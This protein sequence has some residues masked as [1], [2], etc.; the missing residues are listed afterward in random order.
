[1]YISMKINL[2][3]NALAMKRTI[4]VK[5]IDKGRGTRGSL[6]HDVSLPF[7]NEMINQRRA[8]EGFRDSATL[9]LCTRMDIRYS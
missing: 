9:K 8:S 1:M 7:A 2:T 6:C 5:V 4:N 3:Y